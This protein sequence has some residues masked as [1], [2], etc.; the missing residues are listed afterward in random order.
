MNTQTAPEKTVDPAPGA[1]PPAM[2]APAMAVPGVG[3]LRL[4]TPVVMLLIVAV[5]AVAGVLLLTAREQDQEAARRSVRMVEASLGQATRAMAGT[6][7]DYAGWD[8]AAQNLLEQLDLDWADNNVGPYLHG[9]FNISAS[10]VVLDSGAVAYAMADGKRLVPEGTA[11]AAPDPGPDILALVE[12]AR[13]SPPGLPEPV[14]GAVRYQGQ[15]FMAAV[16]DIRY[17][18]EKGRPEPGGQLVMLRRLDGGLLSDIAAPLL[19]GDIGVAAPGEPARDST[20]ALTAQGGAGVAVLHWDPP[21]PAQAFLGSIRW[22][23]LPIIAVMVALTAIFLARAQRLAGEQVGIALALWQSEER[24]RRLVDTMPDLVA[25]LRGQTLVLLNAGG[26]GLLGTD[27]VGPALERPFAGFVA[28]EDQAVWAR[29][30]RQPSA[31]GQVAW[32]D[33]RLRRADGG[34][35]PVEVAL[36]PVDHG[37]AADRVLVARDRT[38]FHADRERL[39]QAE[40]QAAIADRAKGQF[41]SN[42]S[43]ELR[44]PLNAII[45]FSEI[46]RD[47]L[48]GSLG[49]PQY[50]DYALDIHE[51]GLHLLRLV[52]DL[53]DIARIDAGQ[54]ELRE[55]WIDVQALVDRCLRLV[56]QRAAEQGVGLTSRITPPGLRVLA[57]EVRLK[58]MLVNLL[59]NAIRFSEKSDQVT[60]AARVDEAGDFQLSIADQGV[61]MT[62][63]AVRVALQLFSQVEGGHNR[64][65]PGA[66]LGLPL[67]KGYAE[68]HGGTLAITSTPGVGTTVTV[69]L[70][71]SRLYRSV[72]VGNL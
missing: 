36:L 27:G 31:P 4:T 37:G 20:L 56:Q 21:R 12:L 54:L 29:L 66:G 65:Q 53:L 6:A 55:A 52:N 70:P 35:I 45:G 9:A 71:G 49:N 26:A 3:T 57:D 67:A 72:P 58:Q 33:I 14:T 41:L 22:F 5:V 59:T 40:T 38:Q 69:T 39:R 47:E 60:V 34:T 46:L 32:T 68:A 10:L 25:L 23:L 24:Y 19:L 11:A 64:R 30:V 51:G 48:L 42:I 18:Q 50:R 8:D 16:A 61:G 62:A 44:T 17:E 43:H 28:E 13:R 2:A 1:D 7:R 15:P 63:E